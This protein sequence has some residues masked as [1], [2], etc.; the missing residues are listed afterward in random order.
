MS[1]FVIAVHSLVFLGHKQESLTSDQLA[2]NVCTN[3]VRVRRV[4]AKC[5]QAN[6]VDTKRV[7]SG[8]YFLKGSLENI[9]LKDV[10]QAI[11]VPLIQQNWQSGDSEA[12]C[13]VSSGMSDVMEEIYVELN[14]AAVAQL[15]HITLKQMEAKLQ[16]LNTERKIAK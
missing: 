2:E 12:S 11:N 5:K 1:E 13:L 14:Q 8:G 3:P 4:M 15:S 16:H 7:V 10:Y 6:L 9:T